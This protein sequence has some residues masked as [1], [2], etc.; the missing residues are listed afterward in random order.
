MKTIKKLT[1][2]LLVGAMAL[3]LAAC[4]GSSKKAITGKEFKKTLEKADFIVN[5][6]KDKD[7]DEC[8][9]AM[10]RDIS[11]GKNTSVLISYYKFESKSMAKQ[12]FNDTYTDL[13]ELEE[14]ELFDGEMSKNSWKFTAEGEF[15]EDSGVNFEEAYVVGIVA[16][17]TVLICFSTTDKAGK[18]V[19]NKVLDSFGYGE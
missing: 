17:D 13:E 2:L 16:E 19:L 6:S 18:K 15:D 1:A 3:S 4:G 12:C 10:Y 14:D 5:K 7:A 8:Y 11:S 9:E